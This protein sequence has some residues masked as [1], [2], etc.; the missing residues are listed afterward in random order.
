MRRVAEL[1]SLGIIRP[2]MSKKRKIGLVIAG[3]AA[4]SLLWAVPHFFRLLGNTCCT[5]EL[6]QIDGAKT[7]WA[8][9]YHKTTNDIP[10]LADLQPI[11]FPG[12]PN[13]ALIF[14]CPKG[15]TYTIGRVG[16]RPACSI[17]G[18]EHSLP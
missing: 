6:E 7:Q 10:T 18:P 9:M 3:A 4:V 8:L 15:G 13:E 1:W 17:G 11:V 12:R 5:C 14:R 2:H 16:E